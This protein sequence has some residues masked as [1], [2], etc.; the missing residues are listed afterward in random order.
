MRHNTP[1]VET[2]S[3]A[4][5]KLKMFSWRPGNKGD[6]GGES[7][8]AADLHT[9]V[10]FRQ[11]ATRRSTILIQPTQ[12]SLTFPKIFSFSLFWASTGIQ[13]RR[14]NQRSVWSQE[15]F[16]VCANMRMCPSRTEADRIG[17][18]GQSNWR[19]NSGLNLRSIGFRLRSDFGP[20]QALLIVRGLG[21]TRA[22]GR[23]IQPTTK[24]L[25]HSHLASKAPYGYEIFFSWIS[26]L[27]LSYI[28]IL[29][30]GARS[31][32]APSLECLSTACRI[33]S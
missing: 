27:L 4:Q 9:K 2:Y 13:Y 12:S 20:R 7:E 24:K 6:S 10:Y 21:T 8:E 32:E 33:Q 14:V 31:S 22:V 28:Q 26:L 3:P 25:S 1:N 17:P 19:G 15:T 23:N 29:D 11:R 30:R 16:V 5:E 18:N